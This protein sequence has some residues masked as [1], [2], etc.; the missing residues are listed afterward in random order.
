MCQTLHMH[1]ASVLF[2]DLFPARDYHSHFTDGHTKVQ[3][4]KRLAQSHTAVGPVTNPGIVEPQ[5]PCFLYQSAHLS[6]PSPACPMRK[7]QWPLLCSLGPECLWDTA[8]TNTCSM[9]RVNGIIPN[10]SMVPPPCPQSL[11]DPA[12]GSGLP[13]YKTRGLDKAAL[14]SLQ[15]PI[16]RTPTELREERR[17]T[18]PDSSVFFL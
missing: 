15:N 6:Q 7:F 18:E 3:R 5:R 4:G 11:C 2:T 8:S 1:L 16:E 10:R 12:G 9:K 17:E 14:W 13:M